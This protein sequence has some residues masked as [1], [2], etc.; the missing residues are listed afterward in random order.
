MKCTYL[1]HSLRT[2]ALTWLTG[3]HFIGHFRESTRYYRWNSTLSHTHIHSQSNLYTI[4][5]YLNHPLRCAPSSF[6]L[7]KAYA[8]LRCWQQRAVKSIQLFDCTSMLPAYTNPQWP[9]CAEVRLTLT[10]QS[11]TAQRYPRPAVDRPRAAHQMCVRP[12]ST[13][14]AARGHE[15]SLGGVG[16]GKMEVVAN[17]TGIGNAA[18]IWRHV[19]IAVMKP[20][21]LDAI[22]FPDVPRV[23]SAVCW[24]LKNR[25]SCHCNNYFNNA[26]EVVVLDYVR[27]RSH[28]HSF[29]ISTSLVFAALHCCINIALNH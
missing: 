9:A 5:Q 3:W 26:H 20:F 29:Y 15:G 21:T 14:V 16:G 11:L 7:C 8:E 4:S 17:T 6:K 22:S 28:V 19:N 1:S 2:F 23:F 18:V 25:D 24:H 27:F 13:G 10:P 12:F